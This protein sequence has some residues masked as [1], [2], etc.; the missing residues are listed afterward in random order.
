M[1]LA[2]WK[3]LTLVFGIFFAFLLWYFTK[4]MTVVTGSYEWGTITFSADFL[5]A[6]FKVLAWLGI[7]ALAGYLARKMIGQ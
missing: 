3:K 6:L 5:N 4:D 1:A 2:E 7:T